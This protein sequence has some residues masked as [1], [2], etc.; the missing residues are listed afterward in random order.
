LY[1]AC[2]LTL[3]LDGLGEE[4]PLGSKSGNNPNRSKKR[5]GVDYHTSD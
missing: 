4:G 5:L 3:A 1:F 2:G